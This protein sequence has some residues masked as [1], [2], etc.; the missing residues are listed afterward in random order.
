[1]KRLLTL[2][3]CL[4]LFTAFLADDVQAQKA[5]QF[6]YA[7]QETVTADDTVT[8]SHDNFRSIFKLTLDTNSTRVVDVSV[9]SKSKVPGSEII[10]KVRAS[11]TGAS[12]T[13]SFS[14]DFTSPDITVDSLTTKVIPFI[15][16]GS[17]Y[18]GC[19]SPYVISGP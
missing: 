18:I 9:A 13:L 11:D 10:L 8:V 19:G 17:T 2:L 7:S 16:D 3:F 6:G 12:D 1:M 14:S 15:Y 4:S 5:Y